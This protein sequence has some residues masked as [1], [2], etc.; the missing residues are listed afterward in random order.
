MHGAHNTCRDACAYSPQKMHM[1]PCMR[2]YETVQKFLCHRSYCE[3]IL[4][5]ARASCRLS[6]AARP[7]A[8]S[9]KSVAQRCSLKESVQIYARHKLVVLHAPVLFPCVGLRLPFPLHQEVSST[10]NDFETHVFCFLKIQSKTLI[11]P[12]DQDRGLA[13]PK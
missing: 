11:R 7:A 9:T 3:L 13:N 4:S 8:V 1:H 12:R 6:F 5:L 10:T 2:A